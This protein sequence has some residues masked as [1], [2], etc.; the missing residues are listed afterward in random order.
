MKIGDNV[1]LTGSYW[2]GCEGVITEI[3]EKGF[4]RTTFLDGRKFPTKQARVLDPNEKYP[5]ERYY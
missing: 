2:K 1:I 5:R 3:S 4:I